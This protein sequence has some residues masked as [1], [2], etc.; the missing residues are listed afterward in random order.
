MASPRRFWDVPHT[1]RASQGAP[2]AGARVA[3]RMAPLRPL[4]Q[5]FTSLKSSTYGPVG[6][7]RITSPRIC[8]DP[9][10]AP[11]RRFAWRFPA[12]FGTPLTRIAPQSEPPTAPT[13]GV[14]WCP[15]GYFGTPLTRIVPRKEI[16]LWHQR[17]ASHGVP[18]LV[19]FSSLSFSSSPFF[20]CAFSPPRP[21]RGFS[22]RRDDDD[23]HH[24]DHHDDLSDEYRRKR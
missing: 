13:G 8:G 18:S 9:P 10:T 17:A 14:A 11:E 24:H 3:I 1:D 5:L 7:I 16:H 23:Y 6:R 22:P 19:S 21:H 4:R 20:L 2:L 15:S 12:H